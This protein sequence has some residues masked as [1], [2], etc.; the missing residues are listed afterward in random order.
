MRWRHRLIVA[1]FL[2]AA[3][4]GAH[5]QGAEV[6][7]DGLA[8]DDAKH[9]LW[10]ARFWTGRCTGLA[11]YECR[12]GVPF[13]HETMRKLLATVSA[14]RRQAFS[15]RL[16]QLGRKIGHEWAKEND[17]R[18]ISTDHIR[19]WYT[20]LDGAKDNEAA[21]AQIEAEATKLLARK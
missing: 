11:F 12:S 6:P 4:C 15:A 5:A 3:P 21:I 7:Y 17:I 16:H 9:R 2:A 1:A 20:L 13:W 19:S 18:K 10:Y 8:F 14:E